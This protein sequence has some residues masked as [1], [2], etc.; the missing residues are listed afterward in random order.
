MGKWVATAIFLANG[1]QCFLSPDSICD[2]Y[3]IKGANK[4]CKSMFSLMGS[5]MLCIGTY[6]AALIMDK[7]QSEAFAYAMA[8]NGLAAA[9]FALQDA[10]DLKAPKTGPLA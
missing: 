8:V 5:Q 2:M 9:K 7:S 10:D 3:G 4:V 6:L 1:A